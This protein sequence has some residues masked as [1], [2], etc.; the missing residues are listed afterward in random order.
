MTRPRMESIRRGATAAALVIA[1]LSASARAQE[2][3]KPTEPASEANP[4]VPAA[5]HSVHGE[6]FDDGPRAAAIL[7]PGQ[8][9][10]G[11]PITTR[12][13]AAQAFFN[14]G[15]AQIHTFYYLEAERSFRQAAR[16]DPA[17]PMPYWG[18]AM[19]NVNNDKRARGFMKEAQ[20]RAETATLSRRERLYLD[21][22]AGLYKE[23]GDDKAKRQEWVKALETL[24]IEFPDDADARAWLAMVV[25]Q[26]SSKGDGIGSRL[27]VDE[28]LTS[29]LRIDPDHPGGLHYRI[30]LWD[31]QK[32]E[33]A[34]KAAAEYGPAAPG[35]AHAWHMPGHTYSGLQ[36]HADA[37]YQQEASARADHAAM[38]RDRTMPFD[39][40]NYAHNNQWLCTSLSHIGRARDA[41]VVARNLVEQP[42]DPQKNGKNDGGSPQRS[43]RARWSEI[44]VRYELW[45]DLIAAT[46]SAALDWSDVPQEKK[47]HAY[48]LGLAY[49]HKGDRTRLAEQIE[50]LRGM[51]PPPEPKKDEKKEEP[52]PEE[53]KDEPK[54]DEAKPEDKKPDDKKDEAKPEEKKDDARPEDKKDDA[55]PGNPIAK[56]VQN[57]A[58]AAKRAVTAPGAAAALAELEG[59]QFLLDDKKEEAAKAFEKATSMRAEAKARAQIRLGEAD[60]AVATAKTAVDRGVNQFTPLAA[61]VEA[62]DAAGRTAE[63]RDAYGRLRPM[64]RAAD[65]D[66]PITRRLAA[67]ADRWK[68]AGDWSAPAAGESAADEPAA[69]RRPLDTLGPLGWSPT[70]AEPFALADTDDKTWSLAEHKGRNVVV[71]FYLGNKCAHCMQ[72]L[73]E[74]GKVIDDL[75]AIDTDLVAIGTDIPAV[76]KELKANADD[77]KFPMPLLSDPRLD[78]FKAYR[79]FDDFEDVPLHGTFLIDARGQVRFQ[80]ISAEPFL[81]TNFI[82]AEAARVGRMVKP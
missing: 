8:G 51:V 24:A 16:L 66:L 46:E 68:Q 13:P 80:R 23:K 50:V 59:Y 41:I 67:I 58:N 37:A 35:I 44:L 31:G 14:Q 36:R 56:A 60:K 57:V 20:K 70:T 43:G 7:L 19:A 3:T 22:L 48:T 74:F 76:T 65:A 79:C 42:R 15:V 77:V 34:L 5:G 33:Q 17:S 45:D 61:Y 26:N 32:Q 6:A 71:L 25:W 12:D 75:K 69:G 30:H 27:A 39:I 49:A 73:Q 4:A 38:A 29:V 54:K 28:L 55:K 9:H 11:F 47:E 81:D 72:Q 64:L 40:H 1:G 82:K 53:K 63:A 18:M 52:K 2:P 21:G 78:L 10:G 62:L